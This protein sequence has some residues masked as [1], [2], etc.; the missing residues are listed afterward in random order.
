[1]AQVRGSF[2]GLYDNVDKTVF[3]IISETL[4]EVPPIFGKYYNQD[5]SNRK[6][7]RNLSYSMFG[8]APLKGER[9]DFTTQLISQGYTKYFTHLEFG[10]AFEVTQTA[11]ED[12]MEDVI[13]QYATGLA[14]SCRV[15]QETYA[16][17]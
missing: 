13:D 8:A 14:R 5:T 17:V 4:K 11:Q 16:A 7:E 15:T 3:T 1:M 6:F 12:D 10:L 2:P 9:E